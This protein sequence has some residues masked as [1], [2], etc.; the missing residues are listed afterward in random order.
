MMIVPLFF[1]NVIP[2]SVAFGLSFKQQLPSSWPLLWSGFM[3]NPIQSDPGKRQ[4]DTPGYM[5]PPMGATVFDQTGA[6]IGMMVPLNFK[7]LGI[8]VALTK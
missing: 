8:E 6:A 7:D 2:N 1:R 3:C 4:L 5:L